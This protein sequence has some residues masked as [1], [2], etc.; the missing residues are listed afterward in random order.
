MFSYGDQE[1]LVE[2]KR[3]R[4][5]PHHLPR[6]IHKLHKDGRPFLIVVLGTPVPDTLTKLVAEAEPLLFNQNLKPYI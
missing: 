6:A 3:T 2:L 4:E 5:P 1:R